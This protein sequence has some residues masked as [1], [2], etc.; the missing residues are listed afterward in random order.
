MRKL[1]WIQQFALQSVGQPI[2]VMHINPSSI[3][4]LVCLP[5]VLPWWS[6]R[7]DYSWLETRKKKRR[8][9]KPKQKK[10]NL[11]I[12]EFQLHL[13][14]SCLLSLF[15]KQS[16]LVPPQMM[17][18]TFLTNVLSFIDP[19]YRLLLHNL[20][21]KPVLLTQ[22]QSLAKVQ[23]PP[24]SEFTHFFLFLVSFGHFLLPFKKHTPWLI[25]RK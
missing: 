17:M 7:R 22:Q 9:P 25:K 24:T 12:S 8:K 1:L 6:A 15:E 2:S 3:P 20:I 5:C 23:T 14:L 21:P 10:M 11:L 4:S 16:H 13:F 19:S 18:M